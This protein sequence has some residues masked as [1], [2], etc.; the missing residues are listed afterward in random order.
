MNRTAKAQLK[1]LPDYGTCNSGDSLCVN[2]E[3]FDDMSMCHVQ[4]L[5]SSGAVVR[6]GQV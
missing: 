4:A 2:M 3:T 6:L 1:L 5:I